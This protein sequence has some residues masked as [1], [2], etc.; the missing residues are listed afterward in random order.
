MAKLNG[1][2]LHINTV[3]N[4]LKS[5]KKENVRYIEVSYEKIIGHRKGVIIRTDWEY[6]SFDLTYNEYRKIVHILNKLSRR[7]GVF[8]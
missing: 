2:A 6:Y 3:R 7:E 8:S 5:I 1:K 4:I